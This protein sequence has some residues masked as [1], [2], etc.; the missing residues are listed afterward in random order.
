MRFTVNLQSRNSVV[1]LVASKRTNDTIILVSYLQSSPQSNI[2]SC[3]ISQL[4]VKLKVKSGHFLT[5]FFLR[6]VTCKKEHEDSFTNC[7]RLQRSGH[8][9]NSHLHCYHCSTSLP[10]MTR[11]FIIDYKVKRKAKVRRLSYP[12][13][14]RRATF[15]SK[16][17]LDTVGEKCTKTFNAN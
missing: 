13:P 8:T 7:N 17:F 3:L 2:P 6:T 1:L 14:V 12:T 10:N 11:S 9:H 4:K 15:D 16:S 5:T